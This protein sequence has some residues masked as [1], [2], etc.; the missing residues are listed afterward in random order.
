MI[1]VCSADKLPPTFSRFSNRPFELLQIEDEWNAEH[2]MRLHSI[3]A[4]KPDEKDDENVTP[5]KLLHKH[6]TP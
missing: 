6:K 3:Y 5:T 1:I 2:S 4:Y